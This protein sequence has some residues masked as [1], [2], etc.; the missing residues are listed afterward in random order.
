MSKRTFTVGDIKITLGET[1]VTVG[2]AYEIPSEPV[3]CPGCGKEL[4]KRPELLWDWMRS[5]AGQEVAGKPVHLNDGTGQPI[6]IGSSSRWLYLCADC[7]GRWF[8]P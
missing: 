4:G 5:P 2:P 1:K 7:A 6:R 8:E 3:Y